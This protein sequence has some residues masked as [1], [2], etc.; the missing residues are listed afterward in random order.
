MGG[1]LN[2]KAALDKVRDDEL[3]VA[4][5]CDYS[6]AGAVA[7][8]KDGTLISSFSAEVRGEGDAVFGTDRVHVVKAG[9]YLYV[10]G[11]NVG[12]FTGT[13]HIS[14][15]T[16]NGYAYVADGTT[17]KRY[18]ET[19]GLED[20]GFDTPTTAIVQSSTSTTG[21]YFTD[22][23][24]KWV[25]TYYN[26]IAESNF[27][28]VYSK[29]FSGATGTEQV[30]LTIPVGP[31]STTARR[32]Y[33]TDLN[34]EFFFR[35]GEIEDNTTT[36]FTDLGGL[37][38]EADAEAAS[39]DDVTDRVRGKDD[40]NQ[41]VREGRYPV[42]GRATEYAPEQV[43]SEIVLTNL[44]ILAD[45]TDHDPPPSDLRHLRFLTETF[46]G[47]SGNKL[48]FSLTAAPEHWS[49]YNE[50]P[51][52]RQ[53]GE[54]LMAIEPLGDSMVCYTDAGIWLF[55]RIGVD[56]TQSTLERVDSPVGLAAEW[57]VADVYMRGGQPAGHVFLA[58]NG[59][60][61]FDGRQVTEIGLKVEDI[62][63][64]TTDI[65]RIK[66]DD[67]GLAVAASLY[68]QVLISYPNG[69]AGN[70]RTLFI[71]F[72]DPEDIKF[73]IWRTG[74]TTLHR[75][76]DNKLVGGTSSGKLYE[77]LTE[78]GDVDWQV[79]S[80][81][82]PV[83]G[84]TV[85][86][87]MDTVVLDGDFAGLDTEVRVEPERGRGTV[88]T[89]STVSGRKKYR[90]LLPTWLRGN[91]IRVAVANSGEGRRAL[92]GVGFGYQDMAPPQ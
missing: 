77:L 45:W 28:P 29:T 48:R 79:R 33:R 24:Y 87:S 85:L 76:H 65:D 23:T 61:L 41:P 18:S 69:G 11:D 1:G 9:E 42:T 71:D 27:S 10:N 88:F 51:I 30:T 56:A 22:G 35:V 21:G 43:G 59:L 67:I 17:F 19:G 37:P 92:Y 64:S 25:Y 70:D 89:L 90:K 62:F 57:A 3:T 39:G 52:G 26:G 63:T 36:S 7:S 73:S 47:I 72:Q 84:N 80:K 81:Y 32:V 54:T 53:T 58:K 14:V 83:T 74:F 44:G 75:D 49:D 68:D 16:Y 31:A 50:V 86:E 55:R 82:F 6:E 2:Q 13:D 12:S 34:G 4:W 20:V 91:S 66:Q 60:Y 15:Q 5:D 8:R 40:L 78:D 46:Y 38:D